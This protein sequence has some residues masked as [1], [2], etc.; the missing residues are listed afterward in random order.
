MCVVVQVLLP[1]PSPFKME[2]KYLHN[3]FVNCP[4]LK[5]REWPF[6]T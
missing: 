2:I 5:L 1:L 6:D 4:A 3:L